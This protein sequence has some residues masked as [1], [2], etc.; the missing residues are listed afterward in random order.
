M[1]FKLQKWAFK[2]QKWAF[3]SL[4]TRSLSG[5]DHYGR[6]LRGFSRQKMKE[7]PSIKIFA[8]FIECKNGVLVRHP[9]VK[10]PFHVELQNGLRELTAFAERW[11]L[12]IGDFACVRSWLEG[13]YPIPWC[14]WLIIPRSGVSHLYGF[15]GR[16][17]RASIVSDWSQFQ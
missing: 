12:V 6:S 15:A 13:C 5:W 7:M 11:Q 10:Q 8:L 16:S 1:P 3:R 4:K 17:G 2:L 9:F 14:P